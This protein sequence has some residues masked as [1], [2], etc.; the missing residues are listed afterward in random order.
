MPKYSYKKKSRYSYG[1]GNLGFVQAK[2]KFTPKKRY[3]RKKY[4]K[5]RSGLMKFKKSMRR[6]IVGIQYKSVQ[7][8]A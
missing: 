2:R 6:P 4:T 7:M 8:K 1:K 5:K 3:Y